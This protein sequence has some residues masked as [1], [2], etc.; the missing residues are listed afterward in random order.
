MASELTWG[1]MDK[2]YSDMGR[3]VCT[4]CLSN[5]ITDAISVVLFDP[6]PRSAANKLNGL[7]C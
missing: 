1:G 5:H 4:A 3:C 6:Q 2:T 7:A